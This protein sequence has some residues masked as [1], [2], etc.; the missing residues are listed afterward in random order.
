[1]LGLQTQAQV[2]C[3]LLMVDFFILKRMSACIVLV[4]T[5]VPFLKEKAFEKCLKTKFM[6][7]T[8]VMMILTVRPGRWLTVSNVDDYVWLSRFGAV[9]MRKLL[10]RYGMRIA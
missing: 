8:K 10:S 2:S 9:A 7:E 4:Y 5:Y 3:E 6:R 1:M